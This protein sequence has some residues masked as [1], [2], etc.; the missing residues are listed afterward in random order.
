MDRITDKELIDVVKKKFEEKDKALFDLSRL[1]K[2]LE[3][4][5]KRLLESERL[6]ST[7]LSNLK[8][9]LNNPMASILGLC[10]ELRASDPEKVEKINNIADS[11][12]YEALSLEFQLNNILM[13]AEFE[14]GEFLIDMMKMEANS[15][16]NSVIKNFTPMINDKKISIVKQFNDPVWINSDPDKFR[17]I[18]S[19]LISNAILF[20][21][22]G[23]RIIIDVELVQDVFFL[24]VKDDGI[25]VPSDKLNVIFDRFVQLDEGSTK[26]FRGHGLGLSVAKAAANFLN[27]TISVASSPYFGSR[28]TLMLPANSNIKTDGLYEDGVEFFE[29][30]GEEKEL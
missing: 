19:N 12:F 21:K 30:I 17:I 11:L 13:A 26:R 10:E 28:F 25:G 1:N 6:K 27:G 24:S 20:N 7:F 3:E 14:S 9:E 4:T 22:D 23:G 18:I 16:I 29:V 15:I 8:N 2:T 5:N